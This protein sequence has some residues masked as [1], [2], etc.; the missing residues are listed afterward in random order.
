MFTH[1]RYI[2]ELYFAHDILS[3]QQVVVK[4]EL[5]EQRH[6]TLEHEF[7]VYKRLGG[8]MG[9]PRVHWFG[10]EGGFNAM[11]IDRLGPSLEDLFVRCHFQF[12]VQT[13]LLLAHQL[14]SE[15]WSITHHCTNIV[16]SRSVACNTSTLATS[17]TVI[18]NQATL[19]W[20]SA[21]M[22]V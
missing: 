17:S 5:V 15:S 19:S 2:G 8:G 21:V 16:I 10:T 6:H 3:G 14:V 7:Y 4:L 22:P 20:V 12:T 1:Y 13:V 11:V 18:S 9:V